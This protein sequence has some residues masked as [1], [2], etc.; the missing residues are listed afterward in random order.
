MNSERLNH[1]ISTAELE[2]RWNAVRAA[3]DV[4]GLD[5]LVMQ[6]NSETV[7]GYVRWFTDMPASWNPTCVLFPREGLMTVIVHGPLGDSR[8]IEA[9]DPVWRGV[10]E[11]ITTASFPTANYTSEY[12][13][14]LAL[15]ALGPFKHGAIG[16]VGT[17]QMSYAFGSRLR[18]AL[19]G[20]MF[21][22]AS[23]AVD[24]IKAIKSPEEQELILAAARLQDQ[25]IAASFDV[26]EPGRRESEITAVARQVAQELGSEAG[27]Y[28]CG[29]G[30]VGTA[31]PIAPRHLQDRPLRNG[32]LLAL[33]IEVDGPGGM[34]AE[35]GRTCSLGPAPQQ[36]REELEF[37]LSARCF[38][39]Q[40]MRP[41]TPAA[42][43]WAAYNEFMRENGRP[44]ER[45]IHCHGQGYDLVERPFLRFDETMTIEADMNFAC[46]PTYVKD[47]MFVW[48]C[49][50]Y[51]I[52]PEGPGE[53]LHAF[54]EEIVERG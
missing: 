19:P 36:L 46:H 6:N 5:V 52:G 21:A 9:D 13:A 30:P 34:Y 38:T 43:V 23:D 20:A 15:D 8:H 41:G 44:E 40:L 27:I 49:D 32:D 35:I 54:P 16:L 22:E 3:M 7:G 1:P 12:D 47:G 14:E 37:A 39:L 33:L 17:S 11:L 4:E 31:A 24:L 26:V 51:L 42:D 48:I 28:L 10:D 25:V 53:R 45:R 2:R 50:N 18:T 29:A